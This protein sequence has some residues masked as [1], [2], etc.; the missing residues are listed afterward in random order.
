MLDMKFF[1]FFGTN[2]RYDNRTQ[3]NV[4]YDNRTQQPPT[5]NNIDIN[6]VSEGDR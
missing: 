3:T 5:L 4:R 6:T 2:V 1:F